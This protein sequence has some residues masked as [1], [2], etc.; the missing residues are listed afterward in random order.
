MK[1]FI[2]LSIIF[3]IVNC[4]E[5]QTID[6]M[7]HNNADKKW[8]LVQYNDHKFEKIEKVWEFRQN[9][10]MY[11]FR[12]NSKGKLFKEDFGDQV[13]ED[14]Y[15][16]RTNN[17]DE[18]FIDMYSAAYL[19]EKITIDTLILKYNELNYIFTSR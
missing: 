7:L 8:N 17:N 6:F 19:V 16:L 12:V 15:N 3:L 13:F 14:T 1:Y 4:R 2:T 5:K 10:N 11:R 18:L 9:G